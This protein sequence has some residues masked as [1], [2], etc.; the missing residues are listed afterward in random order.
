MKPEAQPG[1]TAQP[2]RKAPYE[3]PELKKI[4]QLRDV[5]AAT[6]TAGPPG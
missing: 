6:K 5:T 4:G 1:D 2:K 3:R